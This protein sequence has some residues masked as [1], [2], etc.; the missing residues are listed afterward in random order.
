MSKSGPGRIGFAALLKFFQ[1]EARFPAAKADAPTAA[2]QYLALQTNAAASA[3]DEYD[4]NGRAIKYHRAEIRAL[5]DFREATVE[6]G[7]VLS[8]W[9]EEHVLARER[10][11]E[12]I[13]EAAL[14]RLRDLK[15]EPPSPDRL[16]FGAACA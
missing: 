16:W 10:H 3:W 5:W 6:D 4:W 13:R 12:R 14:Q 11:P 8:I 15:I 9:L 1:A 7:E 2:V